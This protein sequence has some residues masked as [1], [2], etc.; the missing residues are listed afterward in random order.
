MKRN[1]ATTGEIKIMAYGKNLKKENRNGKKK[2]TTPGRMDM[3]LAG[4]MSVKDYVNFTAAPY[5]V[6]NDVFISNHRRYY[7]RC[8]YGPASRDNVE[9]LTQCD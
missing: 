5:R 4:E 9:Y 7:Y 1:N 6:G 8:T 3:I 2:Y